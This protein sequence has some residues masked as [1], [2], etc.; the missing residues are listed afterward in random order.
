MVGAADNQNSNESCIR[1]ATKGCHLKLMISVPSTPVHVRLLLGT[2][3]LILY[4]ITY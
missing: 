1:K 3:G 4:Q 2:K